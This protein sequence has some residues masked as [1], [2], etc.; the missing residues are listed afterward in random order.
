MIEVEFGLGSCGFVLGR[1][2]MEDIS[3]WSTTPPTPTVLSPF[4]ADL[5]TLA[6]FNLFYCRWVFIQQN[7]WL[8]VLIYLGRIS[9]FPAWFWKIWAE[10]DWLCLG[11][12]PTHWTNNCD[13]GRRNILWSYRSRPVP[14]PV[15]SLSALLEIVVRNRIGTQFWKFCL[16]V[17][18]VCI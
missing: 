6:F 12:M 15:T 17:I 3:N 4:S 9:L 16:S 14:S 18:P 1:T 11:H 13:E 7:I 5:W 10:S 2:D 8:C